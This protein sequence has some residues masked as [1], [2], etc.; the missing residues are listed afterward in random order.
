MVIVYIIIG[1]KWRKY[2]EES[3]SD[4][5]LAGRGVPFWMMGAAYIGCMF[6]GAILTGSTNY[7]FSG[8]M[9]LIWASALPCLGITIFILFFAR[10]LN[11]YG[12]STNAITM[13]D[14]LCDRF[15]EGMRIPIGL[16]TV[17]RGTFGAGMQY[18]AIAAALVVAF[19]WDMRLAIVVAAAS[20][21]AYMLT[22][23]QFSAIV[24]QWIQAIV[25]NLTILVF[26]LSVIKWLGS[27]ADAV[28]AIYSALPEEFTNGL[29]VT[30]SN[31]SVWILTIC[32]YYI[33]DPWMYMNTYLG[34][35]PKVSQNSQLVITCGQ[36]YV[37]LIY[38][39]GM[40]VAAA[41]ALG[42]VTLPDGITGDQILSHVALNQSSLLVGTLLIV[43][44][45]MTIISAAS[46]LVM[47]GT[48]GVANDIY[49]KAIRKG[50]ET[51]RKNVIAVSRFSLLIVTLG[52]IISAIWLPNVVPFWV[53]TQGLILSGTLAPTFAAWF[54]KRSTKQ[55]AFLSCIL[56]MISSFAWAM[57]A[58][59]TTGSP[60]TLI[61]GFHAAHIGVFVSV[62]VM[63]IASLLTKPDYGKAEST[64]HKRLG[65]CVRLQ[66]I[67]EEGKEIKGIWGILGADKPL[68]RLFW[69][70][71][72]ALFL[73]HFL[74]II[75]FQFSAIGHIT[76]WIAIISGVVIFLVYTVMPIFD[77]K[78]F[79][80][81]RLNKEQAK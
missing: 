25:Q 44:L 24:T 55:G 68:V 67:E 37:I 33:V 42:K 11:F 49:L 16:L 31:F 7:G 46:S 39:A 4:Y 59:A 45:V 20:C 77:I 8:G 28:N 2:A 29:M 41:V 64:S 26:A 23:G 47:C 48:S 14:F 53:L 12:R 35:S 52:G 79:I 61:G 62:P 18:I 69:V 66:A 19:G 80:P 15:G 30:F 1:M 32:L 22:A 6:G 78:K 76:I 36:F 9:S 40:A 43:G 71:I 81:D 13:A 5:L 34:K 54:W 65:E 58:W 38:I 56:G 27:P 17:L 60:G 73:A 70:F 10:R 75:F 51:P 50:K 72:A 57:Y 3:S 21:F 63:I 74:L